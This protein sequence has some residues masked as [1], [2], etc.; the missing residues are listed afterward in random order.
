MQ[1]NNH[2]GIYEKEKE[3]KSISV[4]A[5]RIKHKGIQDMPYD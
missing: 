3:N 5:R 4:D 2:S 1:Q